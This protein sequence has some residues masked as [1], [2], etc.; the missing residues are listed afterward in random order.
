MAHLLQL[1]IIWGFPHSSVGKEST[2][3]TGNPSLIPG[4]ERSWLREGIGYPLQYSRASLVTQLV[5]NLLQ[6]GR[7]GFDPRVGKIPWRRERLPTPVFWPAEFHAHSPWGHKE[8]DTTERLSL[9]L[10]HLNPN[11]FNWLKF[12]KLHSLCL[13][14]VSDPILFCS[15]YFFLAIS[16]YYELIFNV[17]TFSLKF[18]YMH[19]YTHTKIHIILHIFKRIYVSF[20]QNKIK[21]SLYDWQSKK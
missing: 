19:I 9:S 3:N 12:P 13:G 8:S 4:S 2:C 10:H 17:I 6:C 18:I 1:F 5:K 14:L 16:F 15:F 21:I 11:Y 20:K 7:P